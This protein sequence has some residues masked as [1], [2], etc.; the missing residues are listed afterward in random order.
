M[1]QPLTDKVSFR[2]VKETETIAKDLY[3]LSDESYTYGSPWSVRQFKD[4]LESGHV[5]Y[6]VAEW[7]GE[8]IGFLVAS[9]LQTEVEIYNL[10][11]SKSY[12]RRGIG[13]ALINE[14]KRMMRVNGITELYLEVRV[15]N[16]PAILLY[17]NLG[18]QPVGVRKN[19]YSN[20]REDAVVL[21]NHVCKKKK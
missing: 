15:S 5:F 1:S 21:K 14:M 4:T 6:I 11:V 13:T 19:Y 18:F 20:P 9:M 7:N 16:E 12:K 2:L 10:V 8:I 17:K 3:S